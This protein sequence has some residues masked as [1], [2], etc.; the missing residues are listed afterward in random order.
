VS[1]S[2]VRRTK[3]VSWAYPPALLEQLARTAVPGA[4]V[5]IAGCEEAYEQITGGNRK[6]LCVEGLGAPAAES[7]EG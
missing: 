4:G 6:I 1:D 5:R 3:A 7:P 2:R